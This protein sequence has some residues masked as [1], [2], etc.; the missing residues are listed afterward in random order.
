[1]V[2]QDMQANLRLF[3]Q[4]RE[5]ISGQTL[6]TSKKK[7]RL[8]SGGHGQDGMNQLKKYGIDFNV[9][10]TYPNG[11]RIGNIPNH[12]KKSKRTGTGQTWFPKSWT[13]KEI[14][15][16]GE[17]VASLKINRHVKDGKRMQGMWKGVR[18]I[19]IRT[20]GQIGTIFPDSVQPERKRG[21][22]K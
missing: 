12:D 7:I 5:H 6:G 15:R 3:I 14:Q 8:E 1:M 18:V 22:K 17:H 4:M 10:K 20:N 9:V 11:V 16:A 2:A 21:K 13:V 19:V